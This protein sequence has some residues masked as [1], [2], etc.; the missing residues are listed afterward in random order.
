MY[1]KKEERK[2]S[3]ET[4]LGDNQINPNQTNT[5]NIQNAQKARHTTIKQDSMQQPIWVPNATGNIVTQPVTSFLYLGDSGVH[6]AIIATLP[7]GTTGNERGRGK[8]RKGEKATKTKTHKTKNNEKLTKRRRLI[9]LAK[10][11]FWLCCSHSVL[12]CSLLGSLTC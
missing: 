1:R 12:C 3:R 4:T 8:T 7:P 5:T 9:S 6:T 10:A 11:A 2:L